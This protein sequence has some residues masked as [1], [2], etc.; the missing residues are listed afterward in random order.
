MLKFS[1]QKLSLG[2][3]VCL[4][5]VSLVLTA[6]LIPLNVPRVQASE[7]ITFRYPPFGQF[8]VAVKDL[9][10][11]A[12]TGEVSPSLSFYTKQATPEQLRKLRQFLNY[13]L[14]INSV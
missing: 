13:P 2:L 5:Q 4:C 6:S 10:T 1:R 14:P 9:V 3:K 8:N 12:E 7:T 11:F